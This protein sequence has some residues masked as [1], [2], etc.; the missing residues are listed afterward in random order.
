MGNKRGGAKKAI[1]KQVKRL[2][3]HVGP[4]RAVGLLTGLVDDAIYSRPKLTRAVRPD[5][6]AERGTRPRTPRRGRVAT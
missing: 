4:D 6:P 5:T 1:K 2:V 3:D